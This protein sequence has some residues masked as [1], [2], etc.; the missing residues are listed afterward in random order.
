MTMYADKEQ[1]PRRESMHAFIYDKLPNDAVVLDIGCGFGEIS[2]M[3]GK[4]C[5][6]VVGID[7]DR[8]KLQ[9]AI[10]HYSIDNVTF[11]C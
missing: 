1:H 11:I 3:L 7:L 8:S 6:S 5:K 4:V 10:D 9:H 2:G